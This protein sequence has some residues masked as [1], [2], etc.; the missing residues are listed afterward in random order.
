MV[1]EDEF[2][3]RSFLVNA[4]KYCVNREV[5][6]FENGYSA[7][8]YLKDHTEV[9]IIISDINM[10][11]MSGF[12]LLQRVKQQFPAKICIIM[13]GDPLNEELAMD[14]GADGFL[15]KP[16]KL[17]NLFD[18]VQVFVIKGEYF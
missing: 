17:K 7:W 6:A 5:E 14:N 11:E 4:L 3:I 2:P 15:V 18:I 13:S 1:V 8:N 16:F 12:E 9:D 10:P